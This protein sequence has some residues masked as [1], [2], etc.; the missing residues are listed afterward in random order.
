MVAKSRNALVDNPSL[1]GSGTEGLNLKL[2]RHHIISYDLASYQLGSM[3]LAFKAL[4]LT[5]HGWHERVHDELVDAHPR[6]CPNIIE[7]QL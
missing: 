4:Y 3:L 2:E 1:F 6:A 5:I 7:L